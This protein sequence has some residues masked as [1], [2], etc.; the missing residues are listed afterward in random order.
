MEGSESVRLKT[1][2]HGPSEGE[3]FRQF[4]QILQGRLYEGIKKEVDTNGFLRS[5]EI[6]A[7][8]S[9]GDRVDVE[10]VCATTILGGQELN[11]TIR[12]VLYTSN[13]VPCGA[14]DQYEYR[15]GSW[16]A[17]DYK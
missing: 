2:E 14:G 1:M 15:D 13:G 9:L 7:T 8:D 10:Y 5:W 3:V 4:K 6:Q 12:Q 17:V 16:I 11:P